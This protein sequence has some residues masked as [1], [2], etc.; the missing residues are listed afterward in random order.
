[1]SRKSALHMKG[2]IP[3]THRRAAKMV[4]GALQH[5]L[6]PLPVYCRL[7]DAGA[8]KAASRRACALYERLIYKPVLGS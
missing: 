8:N 1:M 6:N 5:A 3:R 4:R 7:I 2:Y